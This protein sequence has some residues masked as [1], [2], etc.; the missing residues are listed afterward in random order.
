MKKIIFLLLISFNLITS[1]YSETPEPYTYEE[2]PGV[3]HDL[4]RAEI[5]TLGAMP[6][7]TF[8]VSLGYSFGNYAAHNF[9]SKYFINP[10]AQDSDS[11]YSK[12]EQIGIILTSVGI[13]AGIGIT[14]FI[15]HSVKRNKQTRKLKKNKNKDIIISPVKT[16][17]EAT[18]IEPEEIPMQ[19]V[20]ND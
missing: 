18:K 9:D 11:S 3:L 4:R 6:F 10:F 16:D 17:P 12:D 8:N 7:I 20:M 14:D 15:V 1:I 13:C 19:E 5:I 2:F